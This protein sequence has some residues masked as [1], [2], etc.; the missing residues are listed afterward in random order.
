MIRR[1]PRSTLFPYTTLFRSPDLGR[2]G[3][4]GFVPPGP[5]GACRLPCRRCGQAA[6]GMPRSHRMTVAVLSLVTFLLTLD[7]LV[8][9]VALPALERDL[10]LGA[11]SVQW[12][13]TAF[14]LAFGGFLLLGGRLADAF[15][16]RRLLLAGLA[17]L[18]AG[19]LV[20]GLATSLPVLVTGRLA[21]GLGAALAAPAALA[22]VATLFPDAEERSRAVGITSALGSAGVVAGAVAGG[23]VTQLAGWRWV[24]LG[25]LPLALMVGALV[26]RWVPE[27][28]E[29]APRRRLDAAGAL[30]A[31]GGLAAL[32]YALSQLER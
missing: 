6:C 19:S 32:L 15:G 31:T 13:V 8:V 14:G 12:V 25:N 5:R 10:G 27:A 30:A 1:P 28:Q 20:G 23:I 9:A 3:H 29:R 11:T 21:Q 22:L 26:V 7:S 16:R 24:L 4:D 2:G 18:A 17:T